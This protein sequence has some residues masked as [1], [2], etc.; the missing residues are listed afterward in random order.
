MGS[1]AISF[2]NY[3]S[4]TFHM[5]VKGKVGI[6]DERFLKVTCDLFHIFVFMFVTFFGQVEEEFF[7]NTVRT[8]FDENVSNQ[9]CLGIS[10][11][12]I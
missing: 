7:A 1:Y 3:L 5:K 10:V 9:M 8:V 2:S 12:G 6:I 11:V 4:P